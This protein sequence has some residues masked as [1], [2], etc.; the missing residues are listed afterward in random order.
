M[1]CGGRVICRLRILARRWTRCRSCT[2]D[3]PARGGA[4]RTSRFLDGGAGPS[5]TVRRDQSNP[6]RAFVWVCVALR[7][8]LRQTY[9][10]RARS[11]RVIR[12]DAPSPTSHST[13]KRLCSPWC[14]RMAR[15]SNG[16]FIDCRTQARLGP[17]QG[18]LE[19]WSRGCPATDP[20][21]RQRRISTAYPNSRRAWVARDRTRS[22]VIR[23][24]LRQRAHTT[25][26]ET[27]LRRARV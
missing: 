17:V 21:A 14:P 1:G 3:A 9:C 15:G 18:E 5:S 16:F 6:S 27:K 7:V 8:A 4:Q 2:P 13:R 24:T 11:V 23:A 12:L 10:A 25:G 19:D 26:C 22:L 20:L